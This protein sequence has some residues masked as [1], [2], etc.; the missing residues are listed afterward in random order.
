MKTTLQT[1]SPDQINRNPD[2]PRISFRQDELEVLLNSIMKVG[3]RVPLSVYQKSGQNSYILLDGERRWLC[4]KKLNMADVPAVIEPEPSRIENILRMFNIHNVRVQWDLLAI[5]LKLKEVQQL[6]EREKRP[7]SLNDLAAVTGVSLS[8]V[9][10][11]FDLLQIPQEYLD[12]LRV[13]LK[14]PKAEQEFSEDLFL[15]IMKVTKAIE[16]NAPVILEKYSKEKIMKKFFQKYQND[17]V[18][19]VVKFRDV[20]RIVRGEKAGVSKSKVIPIIERFISE[21]SYTV[22]KAYD[23]SVA[24]AY[25]E[26]SM[27]REIESLTER[28]K[29]PNLGISNDIRESLKELLR[30][31]RS[32]L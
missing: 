14:K 22:E 8:T 17:V 10:R 3:I 28:L 32:I 25:T 18:T 26:R 1:L 16:R 11:S 7:N 2:N 24:K 4:A 29:A 6:L 12:L 20:T 27:K 31:L 15:E 13:E 21:P 19:N 9:K 30:V 5:A 23:S